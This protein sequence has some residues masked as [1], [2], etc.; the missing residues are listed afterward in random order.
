[1]TEYEKIYQFESLYQAYKATIKGKKEKKDVIQ[2]ELDLSN[3]L[4]KLHDELQMKLYRLGRYHCFQIYDPK[5]REIQ[6]LSIRDR[7]VQ[8][9]ICDNVLKPYF[10]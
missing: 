3:Q 9:S 8:H 1:M 7:V 4:W 5:K 2:F 10:G 6:A